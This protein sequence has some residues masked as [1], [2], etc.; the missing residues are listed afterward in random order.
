ML[1]IQDE[2]REFRACIYSPSG[3]FFDTIMGRI[4]IFPGFG[5]AAKAATAAAATVV[6]LALSILAVSPSLHQRIH[7]ETNTADHCCPICAFANGQVTG[8][9]AASIAVIACAFFILGR[10][11]REMT[12]ASYLDFYS[13]PGRAPPR[14]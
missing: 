2:D 5:R 4:R 8:P 10:F 13:P 1:I 9:P 11:F 14:P 3:L 12:V 7:A 6:M